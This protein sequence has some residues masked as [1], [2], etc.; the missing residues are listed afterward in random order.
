MTTA[1]RLRPVPSY[2]VQQRRDLA[3]RYDAAT[4]GHP[5]PALAQRLADELDAFDARNP[6]VRSAGT[7][8]GARIA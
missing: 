6:T 4:Q 1:T 8:G 5:K 7:P 3:A 2:L